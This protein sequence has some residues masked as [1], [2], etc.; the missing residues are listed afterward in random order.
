V[1]QKT[2]AA[3]GMA[4]HYVAREL[5]ALGHDV[6]QIRTKARPWLL[7]PYFEVPRRVIP[8]FPEYKFWIHSQLAPIYGH[9]QRMGSFC[10]NLAVRLHFL[11]GTHSE[12][13]P[14][15]EVAR[16]PSRQP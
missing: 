5:S 7:E 6:R 8:V 10:Q 12:L 16:P 9:R 14:A 4:T 15:Y 1:S 2:A 11:S 3:A 13:A